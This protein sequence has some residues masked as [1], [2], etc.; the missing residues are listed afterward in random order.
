MPMMRLGC[1]VRPLHLWWTMPANR[2]HQVP[3]YEWANAINWTVITIILTWFWN[4][5]KKSHFHLSLDKLIFD[6]KSL[7]QYNW[8]YQTRNLI[9]SG[10][11]IQIWC[12]NIHIFR[13]KLKCFTKKKNILCSFFFVQVF[14]I[15]SNG[16]CV[17]SVAGFVS[18]SSQMS[19]ELK[20]D[21]M[22]VVKAWVWVKSPINGW[23]ESLNFFFISLLYS[24]LCFLSF[25]IT[26]IYI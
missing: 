10:S 7:N 23:Q 9:F 4:N 18:G 15:A 26:E 14:W 1:I 8:T 11:G 19:F 5:P 13:W 24:R 2:L 25:F 22:V 17:V 21:G 6:F 12:I 3:I 20:S 16:V